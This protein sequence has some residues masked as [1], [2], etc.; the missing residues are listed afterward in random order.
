MTADRMEYLFNLNKN[1]TAPLT[2]LGKMT[3]DLF[4]KT[5]EHNL[6][7]I[8]ENCSRFADQLKRLGEVKR[9]EEFF[10]LQKDFFN[11]N[12]AAG[13]KNLQEMV[14]MTIGNVEQFTNI[15][16]T[17]LNVQ[18]TQRT[19]ERSEKYKERHTEKL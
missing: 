8:N 11:E 15:F 4:L 2:L 5:M 16:A 6:E 18:P 19:H 12:F 3:S 14:H 1:F 17:P 9:P 13:I 7:L 10:N